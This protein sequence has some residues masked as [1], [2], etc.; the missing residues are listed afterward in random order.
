[1]KTPK[2]SLLFL[3]LALGAPFAALGAPITSAKTDTLILN[4][5]GSAPTCPTG[6]ACVYALS[7]G[8]QIWD[9]DSSGLVLKSHA[10][11]S[12]RT[13]SNCAGLASPA[14]GDVCFDSSL[15]VFRYYN[16]GWIT[17]TSDD[18]Q[19]VHKAGAETI[20]GVKTLAAA[21]VFGA[22]LT[23]SGSS[24][25][26]FSG[27]SGTFKT[28]TGAVTIGP[29]AVGISGNVTLTS[30]RTLSA[31]ANVLIGSVTDKLNAV[32]LAIASQAVGDLLYADSGS[33][34]ARLADVAAGSVL[35]SGGV[36]AAPAW[37]ANG[38]LTGLYAGQW[39][40]HASGNLTAGG[41]KYLQTAD[42]A[43]E[44]AT[45]RP[46][47]LSPVAMQVLL[48]SCVLQAAPGTGESVAFTLVQSTDR[49]A[50]YSDTTATCTISGT[51]KEC[52]DSTHHPAT[53]QY[54]LLGVKLVN[55]N[56]GLF[57]AADAVCTASM[58]K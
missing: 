1:M 34:F 31:G 33:T 43:G 38:S 36:G 56:G 51:A 49:G 54:D 47:H 10:A 4:P 41:T 42:S 8:G 52:T 57:V 46:L 25:N 3:L 9:V 50:T 2:L 26:D 19:V 24:S 55:S 15:S 11:K 45:P 53:A 35:A 12:F 32:H 27:S 29:G 17:G 39:I 58:A 21:P 28:S 44:A 48:F 16:S 5:L 37:T 23:A 22:G 40:G 13:S 20:T 18:S 6:K 14:N 7:T 30:G